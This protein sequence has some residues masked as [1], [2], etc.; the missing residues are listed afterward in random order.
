MVSS[1][2]RYAIVFNGEIY[3][4]RE[5]RRALERDG[6][7]FR[8]TSDTEVL[9]A[10][11]EREGERMLRR[12]RGMFAFAIWDA[13]SARTV[14]GPRSIRHQAALLRHGPAS[15]LLFA[16]Q[17]KA[18]LA[19]GLMSVEREPAGVAGFYLWGSVP[20]PWTLF[21]DA[22]AL[23]AGHWLRVRDGVPGTPGLLV[24]HSRSLAGAR[25]SA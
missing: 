7:D 13:P 4:F 14:P 21:R 22:F 24:R 25:P 20:E 16:S 19:S 5:L 18:L 8:T 2:G 17:V 6:L 23:P 15:G 3:N 9:L 11:F 10:L 12:L 1:D